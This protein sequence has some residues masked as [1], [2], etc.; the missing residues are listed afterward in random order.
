MIDKRVKKPIAVRYGAEDDL[1]QEGIHV[2]LGNAE[3]LPAFPFTITLKNY[4]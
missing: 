4:Q 3:N 1:G 2:N